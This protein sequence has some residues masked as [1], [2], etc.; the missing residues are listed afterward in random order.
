MRFV[1]IRELSQLCPPMIDVDKYPHHEIGRRLEAIRKSTGL[2]IKDYVALLDLAYTRYINWETGARRMKPEE[3]VLFCD[4]FAVSLDF[5]Y[6]GKLDA[7]PAN[8][9]KELSSMPRDSDQ[10]MSNDMPEASAS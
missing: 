1:T 2:N 5:I 7:L 10:S 6:R 4:K 9:L 8:I 3:A